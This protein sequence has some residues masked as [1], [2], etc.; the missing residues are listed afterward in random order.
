MAQN[1]IISSASII[2]IPLI[3]C[4]ISLGISL[5]APQRCVSHCWGEYDL[6]RRLPNITTVL[7]TQC[8]KLRMYCTETCHLKVRLR[9]SSVNDELLMNEGIKQHVRHHFKHVGCLNN[10][11]GEYDT[12]LTLPDITLIFH[13]QC[14]KI[15]EYCTKGCYLKAR[16]KSY[17]TKQL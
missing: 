11:W 15:R 17:R 5:P 3:A 16:L 10:C 9:A 6:C 14:V 12:C 1:K 4:Q 2:I 8:L 7:Q 13:K